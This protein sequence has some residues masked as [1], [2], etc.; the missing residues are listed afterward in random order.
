MKTGKC[1]F[2]GIA[3]KGPA[4]EKHVAKID[5]MSLRLLLLRILQLGA[6][7]FID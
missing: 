3:F 1:A 6:L 5:E 4:K 2:E 7:A